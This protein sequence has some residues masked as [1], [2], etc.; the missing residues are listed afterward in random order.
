MHREPPGAS[1]TGG[2]GNGGTSASPPMAS[3]APSVRDQG[4]FSTMDNRRRNSS[5]LSVWRPPAATVTGV[6]RRWRTSPQGDTPAAQEVE[7]T[8]G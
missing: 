6:R 4:C 5:D 2:A 7:T 3:V 8:A 1:W